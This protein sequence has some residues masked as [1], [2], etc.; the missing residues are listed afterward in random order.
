VLITVLKVYVPCKSSINMFVK[1]YTKLID[2][3]EKADDE[4]EK[5][6]S[7]VRKNYVYTFEFIC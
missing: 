6:S 3:R 5:N 7:Q 4:A 1:Q 2:D